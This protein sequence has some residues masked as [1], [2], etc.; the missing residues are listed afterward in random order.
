V[1]TRQQRTAVTSLPEVVG[2]VIQYHRRRRG[3]SRE[4]ISTNLDIG[5]S[6]YARIEA[7]GTAATVIQLDEI[8][9]QI[10]LRP[11]EILR[12]AEETLARLRRDN[13]NLV[14]TRRR[15]RRKG[16]DKTVDYLAGAALVGVIG[17]VAALLAASAAD[18]EPGRGSP[19]RSNAPA[20]SSD[21]KQ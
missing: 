17:A 19:G 14:V 4:Q 13:P 20:S 6:T 11:S 18:R 15:Q 10:A 3:L 5:M 2:A 12:E 9:A 16:A 1:A 8:G 7:G 21:R